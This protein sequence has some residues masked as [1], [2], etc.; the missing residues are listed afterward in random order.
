VKLW[1]NNAARL[2]HTGSQLLSQPNG[3][4]AAPAYSFDGDSN[5]GMY[6]R[7][8]DEV[9]F[10]TGGAERFRVGSFGIRGDDTGNVYNFNR[11]L[12]NN[13]SAASPTFSF[14]SDT[15][16]GIYRY[17]TN[18]LGITTGNQTSMI[19]AGGTINTASPSTGSTSGYQYVLRNNS[20]GT[21][22]R[23]TS[24][25]DVKENITNVT[26][27]DA[28]SWMDALQP[29]TFINRWL[30]EGDEPD[31]DRAF[32]EA[33]VQVGFIAD[34]VFANSTT[35][36]FAQVED[37]DGTLKGVGWKW[38]CVIAAAV[39]EIKSLRARVA[40]LEA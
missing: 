10:T 14:D 7:T 2:T 21:L 9:A 19:A 12:G 11:F 32:R 13:G 4:A 30:Q 31:D 18:Q 25:A 5:T 23:F 16:L 27:A 6:L 15:D 26:D 20:F 37:V 39:A 8:S 24:S 40:T 34:D 22:Y 33:D 38:E 17:T 1:A 28:G 3:T 29:V 36:G 35:A